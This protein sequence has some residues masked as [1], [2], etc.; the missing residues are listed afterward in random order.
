[1][2]IQTSVVMFVKDNANDACNFVFFDSEY[3]DSAETET[4]DRTA[5]KEQI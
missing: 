4:K 1:M 3:S 2:N 5:T